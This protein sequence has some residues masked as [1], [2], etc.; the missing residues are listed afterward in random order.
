V[1]QP[2]YA[3]EKNPKTGSQENK[4]GS[5]PRFPLDTFSPPV[6]AATQMDRLR[7]HML[8]ATLPLALR[9]YPS[10][11]IGG[12][13]GFRPAPSTKVRPPAFYAATKGNTG[14]AAAPVFLWT[15]FPH[16]RHGYADGA[17]GLRCLVLDDSTGRLPGRPTA[18]N[19]TEENG[20]RLRHRRRKLFKQ[21]SHGINIF[22]WCGALHTQKH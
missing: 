1:R 14:A 10:Y 6:F 12:E 4:G 22:Y 16:P 8:G 20:L 19:A 11:P 3:R 9:R 17:S 2:A 15:L 18:L 5:L 13:S 21:R 7:F